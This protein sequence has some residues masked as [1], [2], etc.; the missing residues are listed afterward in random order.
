ME[1]KM[2]ELHR[3]HRPRTLDEVIGQPE[4]VATLKEKLAKN[5]LPQALMLIGPPGTGKTTLARILRRELK[6]SLH[7]FAEIN[8]ANCDPMETVRDIQRKMGLSPMGGKSRMF[9]CDE[10]QAMSRARFAQQGMLKMLEDMPDHVWF[11]LATTEPDK[12]IKAIRTRCTKIYLK[13]LT[14]KSLA[15]LISDVVE[16]EGCSLLPTVYGKIIEVADGSAREAL[17][18]LNKVIGLESEEEQLA[19]VQADDVKR[20]AFDLVKAL[21]YEKAQW[22]SVAKIMK[23]MEGE[24]P[25]SL[26]R[27]ILACAK[28]EA[29]KAGK[30]HG[31]AYLILE[32]F[33]GNVF[34]SGFPGLVRAAHEVC[35]NK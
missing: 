13:P 8:C 6:C 24:D 27:M 19:A 18:Q 35:G 10:F 30:N 11:I 29:L 17:N 21:L 31:Q 4:A 15:M 28:T 16:K 9:Y 25:E 32:C 3:K 20:Q 2:K 12:I 26:R 23:D 22:A 14:S 5:S 7:D 33:N 1:G 34:D